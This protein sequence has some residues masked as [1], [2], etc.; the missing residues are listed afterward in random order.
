MTRKALDELYEEY[1][2]KEKLIKAEPINELRNSDLVRVNDSINQLRKE[3]LMQ[4]EKI[5]EVSLAEFRQEYKT[6][7]GH[8][9]PSGSDWAEILV[10]KLNTIQEPYNRIIEL[11]KAQYFW[12]SI[13]GDIDRNIPVEYTFDEINEH[14]LPRLK[15]S[16][17]QTNKEIKRINAN[18][19]EKKYN[20]V[21]LN[22]SG[23][24]IPETE[25][26]EVEPLDKRRSK[27]IPK[28][29]MRLKALNDLLPEFVKLIYKIDSKEEKGKLIELITGV[30]RVDAYKKT[31]ASI[32]LE[33]TEEEQQIINHFKEL[34]RKTKSD[35]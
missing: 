5:L 16:I 13:N 27:N 21:D 25:N 10:E 34:I 1:L 8:D 9:I 14:L 28:N 19:I 35:S 22:E 18:Y 11:K 30:N 12:D 29:D 6:K 4:K 17:K 3:Y 20:A 24:I 7:F 33:I 15:V 26:V 31:C 2:R 23:R 32:P